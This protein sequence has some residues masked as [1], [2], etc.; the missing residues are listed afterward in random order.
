MSIPIS[1]NKLKTIT[2]RPTNKATVRTYSDPQ[3]DVILGFS[4]TVLDSDLIE[5]FVLLLGS[6]D[7]D[8][9]A[10]GVDIL[11]LH[12]T[13]SGRLTYHLYRKGSGIVQVLIF[14]YLI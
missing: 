12:H 8:D 4:F 7:D 3:S 5:T 9:G 14:I 2:K 10:V 11:L 1:Y 6:L 13:Y